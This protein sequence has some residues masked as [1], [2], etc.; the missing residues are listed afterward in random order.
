M[1]KFRDRILSTLKNG[2][3]QVALFFLALFLL[4]TI[5]GA[6]GAINVRMDD[7][8]GDSPQAEPTII[9]TP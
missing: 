8:K 7:S 3:V 4:L 6:C 1:N 2:L 5:I 9:I